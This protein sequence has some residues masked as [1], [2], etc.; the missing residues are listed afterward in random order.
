MIIENE[1]YDVNIWI[2]SKIKILFSKQ[3]VTRKYYSNAN[4]EGSLI[5]EDQHFNFIL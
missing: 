2:K 4:N 3:E 1:E 5:I